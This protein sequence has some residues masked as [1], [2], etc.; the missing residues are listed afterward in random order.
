MPLQGATAVPSITPLILK[1][2]M[3]ET[4][5]LRH[6][7]WW[8]GASSCYYNHRGAYYGNNRVGVMFDSPY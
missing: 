4:S 2:V 1:K 8:W 5:P 7:F 6:P 3:S